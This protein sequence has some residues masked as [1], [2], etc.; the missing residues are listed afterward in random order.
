MH[1]I[2]GF[3]LLLF[4]LRTAAVT[5]QSPVFYRL[6][7][8][9][10]L[11]SKEVYQTV[12]D[13]FGY[14][15]IGCSAGLFRFDG[16][17]FTEI[18]YRRTNG[19][20]ISHLIKALDGKIWCQNF[21]GQIYYVQG[22]SLHLFRDYSRD[23]ISFPQFTIDNK[24]NIWIALRSGVVKA[25][26]DGKEQQYPYPDDANFNISSISSDSSGIVYITAAGK[27]L[28][29]HS[30]NHFLLISSESYFKNRC[31]SIPS[32]SGN[33]FLAEDPGSKKYSIFSVEN[34]I[35][36]LNRQFEANYLGRDIN[37]VKILD[38]EIIFCTSNGVYFSN[39]YELKPYLHILKNEEISSVAQD[40]EKS[41]WFTSLSSGIIVT[42][43]LGLKH[44]SNEDYKF[45][46]LNFTAI[47]TNIPA[48]ILAGNTLGDVYKISHNGTTRLS[49]SAEK[50]YRR[51]NK[52]LYYKNML[53]VARGGHLSIYDSK[54]REKVYTLSYIRDL[55][56]YDNH[57]EIITSSEYGSLS[58]SSGKYQRKEKISA[59]KIAVSA[60]GEI[61]IATSQ[62]VSLYLNCLEP[63]APGN[64]TLYAS[65][66][67]YKGDT[68]YI[69]TLNQGVFGL[70]NKKTVVHYPPDSILKGKSIRA[71]HSNGKFLFVVTEYGI[72]KINTEE[73]IIEFAGRKLPVNFLGINIFWVLMRCLLKTTPSFLSDRTG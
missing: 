30:N 12:Q 27:G 29:R 24:N 67:H 8:K 71:I 50:I 38:N 7:E 58:L 26:A 2:S 69:G 17:N 73:N 66:L 49:S 54:M 21:A 1:R 14:M 15:Y 64:D 32:A 6:D 65:V 61:A 10:N 47:A 46:N 51:A 52:I 20:S 60:S 62:G 36:K 72:H 11:P 3:I 53:I 22:D 63:I 40:N 16:Y 55:A 23:E 44:F 57:L 70:V 56:V 59:R 19:K 31:I 35:V 43:Y 48:G 39:I 42:P 34:D 41:F 25:S 68:L 13:N 18:G 9:D 45:S 37:Q 33:W 4:F 5:A 28:Y